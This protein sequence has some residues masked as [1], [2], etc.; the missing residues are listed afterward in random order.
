M[1]AK[2]LLDQDRIWITNDRMPLPLTEMDPS[3][4]RN[5][6]AFLRRRARYLM[7]AYVWC[8]IRGVMQFGAPPDDDGFENAVYDDPAQ[9]LERRPL[10]IELARLVRRDELDAN[11]VEG[12][13][14][15]DRPEPRPIIA[16]AWVWEAGKQADDGVPFTPEDEEMLP[17]DPMAA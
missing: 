5:T 15:P 10:V 2:A 6:L 7:R 9:W 4:R 8:E 3:H 13:V 1:D 12:E 17:P 11:T 16:A 14:V